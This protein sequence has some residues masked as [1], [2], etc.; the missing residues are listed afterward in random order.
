M[1]R[2]PREE[3][4]ERMASQQAAKENKGIVGRGNAAKPG[5]AGP[6]ALGAA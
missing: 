4:G 3:K 6:L 1:A 2:V 5:V